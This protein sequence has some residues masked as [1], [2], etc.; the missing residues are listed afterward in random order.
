MHH[1]CP[2]ILLSELEDDNLEITTE[3]MHAE[4][5]R[6]NTSLELGNLLNVPPAQTQLLLQLL[7]SLRSNVATWDELFGDDEDDDDYN[8]IEDEMEITLDVTDDVDE[9]TNEQTELE[10]D[11]HANEQTELEAEDMDSDAQ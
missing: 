7:M 6:Y 1:S 9:H 10:V 5:F 8:E 2:N 11:E 3:V 4:A